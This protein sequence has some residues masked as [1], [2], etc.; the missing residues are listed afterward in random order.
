V[1]FA[2]RANKEGSKTRAAFIGFREV[3]AIGAVNRLLALGFINPD[4][5]FHIVRNL[6]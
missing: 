6:I 1:W 5:Q 2:R 4:V 3:R